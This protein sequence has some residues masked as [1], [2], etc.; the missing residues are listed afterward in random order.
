MIMQQLQSSRRRFLQTTISVPIL[1]GLGISAFAAE[2]TGI[3]GATETTS[4][5]SKSGEIKFQ[6]GLAS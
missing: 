4:E 5:I 3:V 1:T 2:T 6:L